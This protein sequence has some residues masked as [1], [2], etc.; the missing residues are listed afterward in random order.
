MAFI[1]GAPLYD[2]IPQYSCKFREI[3]CAAYPPDRRN[4]YQNRALIKYFARGLSSDNMARKLVESLAHPA[5]LEDAMVM[6][7][8]LNERQ[9]AYQRLGRVEETMEVGALHP[10]IDKKQPKAN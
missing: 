2:T 10:S 3:A 8:R 7:A 1:I 4:E 6:V 5:V 9:D